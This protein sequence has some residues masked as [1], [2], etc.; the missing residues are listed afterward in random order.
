MAPLVLVA[1]TVR[2]RCASAGAAATK[3]SATMAARNAPLI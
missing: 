1:V 3:K 2:V